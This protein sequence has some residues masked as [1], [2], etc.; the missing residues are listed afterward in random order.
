MAVGV[1]DGARVCL[2]AVRM[3]AKMEQSHMIKLV[4]LKSPIISDQ[5][6]L[7]HIEKSALTEFE[8]DYSEVF[9]IKK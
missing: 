5:I 7:N 2:G 9:K 8:F 4:C 3:L 6:S 1:S